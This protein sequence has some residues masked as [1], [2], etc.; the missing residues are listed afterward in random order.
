MADHGHRLAF[1]LGV[2]L[3]H[4]DRDFLVR[5]GEDFRLDVVAVVE[6]RLV[7]AA[8]ARRAVHRQV[9]DVERLEDVDH[10]VAAARGLR[11][12]IRHRRLVST[13]I[14][15]GPG[16]RA[17]RRRRPS[18]AAPCACG[19][20]RRQRRGAG[21][22]RAFEEVAAA[23]L[24]RRAALGHVVPPRWAHRTRL[25]PSTLAQMRVLRPEGPRSRQGQAGTRGSTRDL[26]LRGR[27]NSESGAAQSRAP[28]RWMPPRGTQRRIARGSSVVCECRV[29]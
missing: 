2:A 25:T 9:V 14:C 13:A 15:S 23:G 29:G 3:P 1:D 18:A 8:E 24:R 26:A 21:E 17:L 28:E 27:W 22:R 4:V 6:D 5:A 12:R 20:R 11:H 19:G 7:Q 10:E 16:G